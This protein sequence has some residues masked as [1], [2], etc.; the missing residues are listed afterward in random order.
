VT[1]DDVQALAV[2]ALAHRVR[3]AGLHD[4]GVGRHDAERVI[5]ELL[6]ELPVPI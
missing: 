3:V 6:S 2:H 1:P 4:S 5:R